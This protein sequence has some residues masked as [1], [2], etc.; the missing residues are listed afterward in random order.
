MLGLPL[1]FAS[2]LVLAALALLPVIWWLLRLT[3]PRPQREVFPPFRILARLISREETPAQSPW[4]LTLLRLAIAFLVILAM[5]GPIWNPDETRLRGEGPVLIALDNGWAS[6]RDWPER[7]QVAISLAEEAQAASRPVILLPT[8]DISADTLEAVDASNAISRLES[9]DNL[10]QKPDHAA[11][12]I[13]ARGIAARFGSGSVFLLSDGL[14]RD[15]SAVFLQALAGMGEQWSVQ[16][17]AADDVVA[18]DTVRNDPDAMVG[19]VIRPDSATSDVMEITAYDVN[20]LPLARKQLR[21]AAG[22]MRSEFRLTEP[23]ELRN[24]IV[25]VA[26]D[27]AANPGAVQL[28]DESYRR[29]LV[30]LISGEASDLSQPLLSPLYYIAKALAPFSDI[31]H[32]D[33][34]NVASAVPA[35][36]GQGVSAIVMADIGNIPEPAVETLNEWIEKGGMLIRFAGPRLA[37]SQDD[38]LL[39]V[40]LRRG[41]RSLGGS[42]SWETPKPVAPFEAGSPFF[43]LDPPREVLVSRQVLALQDIDLERKTWA[44]LDDGTPLVTA[45]RKGAGWIVLFHVSSDAAWSNLP[46]SGTFVEMLRRVVNQSSASGGGRVTETVRLPP[47]TLLNGRGEMAPPPPDAQPLVIEEGQAPAVTRENPP[48]L[49]GTEDGFVALNLMKGGE[50]LRRLEPSLYSGADV[51]T[52]YGRERALDLLPW[53][54]MLAAAMLVLDCVAV[55]VLSGAMRL[56]QRRAAAALFLVGTMALVAVPQLVVAQDG[57][58]GAEIDYSAALATR[59]AYVI[60]GVDSVDEIS[61]AGLL[62]LSQFV[63]S[64]TALEPAEPIGVDLASDELAFYPLIYWPIST[65]AD[66]PSPETMARV[67]AFMRQGGTILFDTRDQFGGTL[68]GTSASAEA[69]MLQAILSGLDIPPL[70]PVP[71]DHVLTKAFYLLNQFPGRYFG[72]DLWVEA[73]GEEGADPDRPAR[74]GDGVSSILITSNDMAGAWAV[75]ASFRPMFPTIPPDPLQREMSYRAGVNLVMYAMTGNYK[76]DQVHVPALLER[77]GQ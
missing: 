75:D 65:D 50:T 12:A 55:L 69:R 63:A 2:P 49:Y 3:P 9:L 7:R 17:P 28:L 14:A 5:S 60:T 13:A 72:G 48:G 59:F 51:A 31:R 70:E 27:D 61:R 58:A 52:G 41:D 46:I 35:L 4:W 67:D 62:G 26:V 11:A 29:R 64:R 73:I 34:A 44:I 32:S 56:P 22:E 76:A 71:P 42:L 77:L 43:G 45:D 66:L 15:G 10:P 37:G 6:G 23:V 20:G 57:K 33:E 40:K 21:L 1:A 18:I 54:L 36:I 25:R 24:Q 38:R 53:L 74:G 8:A 47:L 39:P 68:G 30:G 16:L 19:T